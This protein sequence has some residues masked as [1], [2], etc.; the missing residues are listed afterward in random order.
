MKKICM[1]Y[2]VLPLLLAIPFFYGGCDTVTTVCNPGNTQT[3][4]CSD[5]TET[6]QDCKADGTAWEDCDCVDYTIWDDI[7]TDLSWQ[8]PQKDAYTTGDPGLA[9]PD[10]IRYCDELVIG[11]YD[12]WKLPDIDELRTIIRGNTDT[13]TG[14]DCP[15]TEGS[16]KGD[17]SDLAS[18]PEE[19]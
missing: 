10:A 1:S 18:V 13:E 14:G 17:M 8:D 4:Y 7:S 6:E 3:C 19:D 11:G 5:G 9:Q 12:D 16:P 15:I 2:V